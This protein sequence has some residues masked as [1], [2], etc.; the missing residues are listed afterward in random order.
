MSAIVEVSL[1]LSYNDKEIYIS[2][3]GYLNCEIVI[4]LWKL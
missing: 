4:F 1:S 3:E 2:K